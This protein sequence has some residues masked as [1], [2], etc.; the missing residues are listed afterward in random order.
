MQY[1]ALV[2][3]IGETVCPIP[4]TVPPTREPDTSSLE[5]IDVSDDPLNIVWMPTYNLVQFDAHNGDS[6]TIIHLD[7]PGVRQLHAKLGEFI[8]ALECRN[9]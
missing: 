6:Q 3:L 9:A 5:L 2:K 1:D 4:Y 8:T 7:L